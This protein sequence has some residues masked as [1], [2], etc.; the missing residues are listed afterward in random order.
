MLYSADY[1]YTFQNRPGG[2]TML[3]TSDGAG[4]SFL[5]NAPFTHE[6]K[7]AIGSG[8]WERLTG[9]IATS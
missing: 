3:D 9:P 7:V 4:R 1:P 2:N 5:E 6:E 8:N